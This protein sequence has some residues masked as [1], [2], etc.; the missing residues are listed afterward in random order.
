M[1][2]HWS[3]T[4]GEKGQLDSLA[5][6][7]SVFTLSIKRIQVGSISF[8]L[9]KSNLSRCARL[10]MWRK[11]IKTSKCRNDVPKIR[12]AVV[13]V[14]IQSFFYLSLNYYYATLFILLLKSFRSINLNRDKIVVIKSMM[15]T[16]KS[17]DKNH[18]AR[19]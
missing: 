19:T 3:W 5:K 13:G 7:I 4:F 9:Q 15:C 1:V 17:I 6:I 14:F 2:V 10:W 16:I 18:F 11:G 12:F 8:P